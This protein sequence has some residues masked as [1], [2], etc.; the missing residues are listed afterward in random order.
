MKHCKHYDILNAVSVT[1]VGYY[2]GSR[3][4]NVDHYILLLVLAAMIITAA[5]TLYHLAKLHLK[6][7]QTK[8]D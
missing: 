3:I 6:K 2:I 1:L 7:R 8:G 5:P 4:P